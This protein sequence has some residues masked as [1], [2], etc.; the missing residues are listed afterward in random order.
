MA[1]EALPR[2]QISQPSWLSI[3]YTFTICVLSH[4]SRVRLCATPWTLAH[5]APLSMGFPKQEYWNG[6]SFPPPKIEQIGKEVNGE[7]KFQ[8][9]TSLV[10]QWLRI[11]LPMQRTWVHSLVQ[12]DPTC[13]G[14]TKLVFHNY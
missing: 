10:V 3:H 7:Y 14:A 12:E 11:Q 6:L 4:F 5:Q 1:H 9:R 8:S 13:H 2:P